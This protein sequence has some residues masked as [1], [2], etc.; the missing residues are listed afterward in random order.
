MVDLK[1]YGMEPLEQ[2][3]AHLNSICVP[4]R[5]ATIEYD[6]LADA[7][8]WSDETN[9]STP[10]DVIGALRPLRHYRTR[11]MLN[12]EEPNNIVWEYCRLL[13]PNWIGFLPE[14]RRQTPELLARYRREEVSSR[15][16]L[17]KLER[18]LGSRGD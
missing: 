8:N 17:R 7:L 15:W 12:A 5:S 11:L 2:H 13:F 10:S 1:T 14:R 18:D 9:P 6:I 16:C 3:A 4:N